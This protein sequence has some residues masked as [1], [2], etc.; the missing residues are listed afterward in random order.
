MIYSFHHYYN[1]LRGGVESGMAYRAKLFRSVGI[2]ARFVFATTFP[3][4]N[5][6]HETAQLGFLNSEI[7]W[8]YGF[9]TNCRISPVTY[10]LEQLEMSFGEEQYTY[11][12]DGAYVRYRFLE[13]NQYYDVYLEDDRNDHVYR[14]CMISNGCL[15][16][17]DYYTYCRIFSEYYFPFE[18]QA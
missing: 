18:G 9:F 14:V 2:D 15:I 11:S 12:R 17:Q 10:T 13:K 5:I 8:L 1:W 3:N 7:M 4:V 16:R 6:Q